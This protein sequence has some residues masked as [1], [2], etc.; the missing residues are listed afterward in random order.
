[1]HGDEMSSV[2]YV[3]PAGDLIGIFGDGATPDEPDAKRAEGFPEGAG[4][5]YDF[6]TKT[7][8][9]PDLLPAQREAAKLSRQAFCLALFRQD[10]LTE[11]DA[12]AAAK[13][14]WPSSL[15][16]MLADLPPAAAAEA[17][18][19]WATSTEI[20]RLHP[21]L[22]AIAAHMSVSDEVL[23]AMFGIA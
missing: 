12:I 23:D 13:G 3:T 11:T 7:W 4:S 5:T 20:R 8:I 16:V 6:G 19:V 15:D 10:L 9:E 1:M 2:A 17:R 18:I 14:D 21:L 22:A